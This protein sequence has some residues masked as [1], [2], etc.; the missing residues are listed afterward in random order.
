MDWGKI[1]NTNNNKST[2]RS[3][4]NLFNIISG[5]FEISK[6]QTAEVKKKINELK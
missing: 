2:W 6:Q 5:N 4:K 1:G 3:T